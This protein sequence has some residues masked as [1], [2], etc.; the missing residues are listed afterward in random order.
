MAINDATKIAALLQL[1][2]DLGAESRRLAILG[3]GNTSVR[4]GPSQFAIK[5][6]GCNL[7]TLTEADITHCDSEKIL[8]LLDQK[9]ATDTAIDQTLFD[10]RLNLKSK[11]PSVESIFHAWLLTLES[12]EYV[13]HTH[14]VTVNQILCSPRARDFAEQRIFPDEIVCC[15]PAS[16]FVP[17]CDPGLQLAREIRD[18]TNAFIKQYKTTPRLI[19]LQN[20]GLIALG[21]TPNAVLAATLMADKSAAIFA[22][23]ASM[24]GPNHLTPAQVERIAGR[25]DEAHR[26]R[27]LKI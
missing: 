10:A 25:A 9:K 3:E 18:R 8:K 24:G 1:S 13:G 27:E 11:K 16:V 17:Y 14:P 23:A 26:Q 7:A 20:H 5:A 19:L 6:S 12:V 4:L 2:H 15:G 22:G 21:P